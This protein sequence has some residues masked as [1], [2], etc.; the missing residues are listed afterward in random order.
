MNA[1]DPSKKKSAKGALYRA[2]R[3][4]ALEAGTKSLAIPLASTTDRRHQGTDVARTIVNPIRNVAGIGEL[5]ILSKGRSPLYFDA[6]VNLPPACGGHHNIGG[7]C[8]PRRGTRGHGYRSEVHELGPATGSTIHPGTID[9]VEG[10][11]SRTR[12]QVLGL[13]IVALHQAATIEAA[14]VAQ[15]RDLATGNSA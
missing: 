7:W 12:A 4:I 14:G 2:Q 5:G 15:L 1:G 8:S 11:R 9:K 10:R 3:S 13:R 6:A